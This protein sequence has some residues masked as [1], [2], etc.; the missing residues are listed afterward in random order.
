VNSVGTPARHADE[1]SGGQRQLISHTAVSI[2]SVSEAERSRAH[3]IYSALALANN[4][5]R[6]KR[7][8]E[9]RGVR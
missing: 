5:K 4:I 3:E 1:G 8:G 6:A 9:G 7:R 2:R